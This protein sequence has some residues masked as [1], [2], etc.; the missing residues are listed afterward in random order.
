MNEEELTNNNNNNNNEEVCD[1]EGKVRGPW[2]PEEDTVLSQLVAKFGARNWSL[3]ARGIPG[4]SGKSCRL[5]WCNQ[6]DPCLK[7]KPFTGFVNVELVGS[8][9]IFDWMIGSVYICVKLCP[10]A[11]RNSNAEEEDLIIIEAHAIHG[12]KWAAIARIL[13]GRTDNAIKNHWNSTLRRKYLSLDTRRKAHSDESIKIRRTNSFQN[14][15]KLIRDNTCEVTENRD[16]IMDERVNLPEVETETRELHIAAELEQIHPAVPRPVPRVSAFS[17]YK[18][19]NS[20]AVSSMLPKN[21]PTHGPLVQPS[22]PDL[23]ICK[24]LQDVNSDPIIPL[25]CGHGCC[26]APNSGNSQNSLLGPEFVD[27]EELPPISSKELISIATD[28]NSIAWI[29]SGLDSHS[30][31]MPGNAACQQISEPAAACVRNVDNGHM[32]FED[33]RTRL[34]NGDISSRISRPT[35]A[36]RTEVASLS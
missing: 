5:R 15:P 32:Q 12:N 33:G 26:T 28:L 21:V 16:T 8:I 27:Y 13:P 9:E 24:Y 14:R 23:G 6:L 18:P 19:P 34:M 3:M 30:A 31:R 17:I 35:V 20:T 1:G 2:S 25:R 29:K 11:K 4:R 10:L 7:R 36:M 22:D